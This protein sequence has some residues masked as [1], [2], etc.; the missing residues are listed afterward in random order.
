MTAVHADDLASSEPEVVHAIFFVTAGTDPGIPPRL[1][2]PF[3]KLG[4]TPKRAHMS[5]ESGD[6]R[7]LS[8]DLRVSAVSPRTVHILELALRRIVG[9]DSVVTL[10]R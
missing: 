6:G 3:A 2:A 7:D 9:V 4:L 5:C 10:V 8:A 1:L